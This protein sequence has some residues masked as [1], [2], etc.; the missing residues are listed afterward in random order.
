MSTGRL[1]FWS[2][3]WAFPLQYCFFF[4]LQLYWWKSQG[5]ADQQYPQHGDFGCSSF[6]ELG[7]NHCTFPEMLWSPLYGIFFGNLFSAGIVSLFSAMVAAVILRAWRSS[8]RG[9][10]TLGATGENDI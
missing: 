8:A 4:A 1:I 9:G 6:F 2:I 7:I 5:F 3:L 10:R